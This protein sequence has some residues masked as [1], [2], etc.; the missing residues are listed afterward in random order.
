M[1]KKGM[2]LTN[3]QC[4]EVK[5]ELILHNISSLVGPAVDKKPTKSN[6]GIVQQ[7]IQLCNIKNNNDVNDYMK[8][9]YLSF[10]VVLFVNSK[11][12]Q[13]HMYRSL[14]INCMC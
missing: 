10:L 6:K 11:F 1:I 5:Q 9:T 13:Y 2:N 8:H 4:G 12:I 3:E 7:N 14:S